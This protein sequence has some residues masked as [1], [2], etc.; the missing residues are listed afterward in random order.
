[1]KNKKRMILNILKYG[2]LFLF[3]LY[4]LMISYNAF[5][6]DTIVNYGFSYAIRRGEVPYND[7]NLVIPLFS[8]LFYTISL[9]FT[10]N[11]I[12]YYAFQSLLL[13]FF[14]ILL[15][16]LLDKKV[17]LLLPFIFLG[18][19][20]CL[21]S[22][23]FPGYNFI[24]LFLIVLL[25]YLEKKNGNDYLIGF[26]IGLSIITK[27]TI[28][29]FLILPSLIYLFSNYKK[30]LKRIV[31]ILGPCSL[32]L[33]YLVVSKSFTNFLNLCIGGL[34]DFAKSNFYLESSLLLI[35]LILGIGY[36]TYSIIRRKKD[37][38]NYYV[39]SSILFIYPL[40][41]SYH[42]SYFVLLVLILFLMNINIKI[43]SRI[44]P[45]ILIFIIVLSG[46][47]T[48]IVLNFK[49]CSFYNFHNY[50][51]R[52]IGASNRNEILKI[53]K[54]AS[55]TNKNVVMFSLG[56]E[57]YFYKIVNDLDITYFDL[58]NYGNYGYDSYKMMSK[59]IDELNDTLILINKNNLD[60]HDGQQYYKELAKYVIDNYEYVESLN[61]YD[62]YYKE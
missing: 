49:D 42:I 60:E 17:Y 45:H 34:F 10:K 12:C 37:I 44:I 57:N 1:M 52:Y 55:K 24:L 32:F 56:S 14:F 59:K 22:A 35:F 58:P 21:F 3:F 2:F 31:G 38:S 7:F 33:F 62:I 27:H 51:L 23:L 53:N 28:G 8:P 19:P 29:L 4:A 16:K 25:I 9:I 61:D 54:Y 43:N 26:I 20:I 47:W 11:V 39:L 48:F 36:L 6:G 18:Y 50:P 13:V 30:V 15:E 41:D 40:I 46:L 5:F